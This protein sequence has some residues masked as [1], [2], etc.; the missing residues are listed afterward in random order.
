MSKTVA[1]VLPDLDAFTGTMAYHRHRIIP[2]DAAPSLLLT[3]GAKYVADKAGAY[4]LMDTVL[5]RGGDW[6]AP[7]AGDSFAAVK[8]VVNEDGGATLTADDGNDN[9]LYREAISFTDFPLPGITFYLQS[10]GF[11][12]NGRWPVGILM[13]PSEY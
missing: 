7:E 9:E 3:D 1:E 12:D 11:E 10:H 6:L 13:L 8:L 5:L 4:W 2:I